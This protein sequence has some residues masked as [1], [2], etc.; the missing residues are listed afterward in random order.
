[1]H[2]DFAGVPA[3][4][5]TFAL[6]IVV[7]AV[8]GAYGLRRSG[9]PVRECVRIQVSLVLAGLVPA[10]TDPAGVEVSLPR[11]A[12][13]RKAKRQRQLGA[14]SLVIGVTAAVVLMIRATKAGV[15]GVN[16]GSC[17]SRASGI[18]RS[19]MSPEAKNSGGVEKS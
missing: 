19:V 1:M 6:G 18:S 16:E 17:V 2:P 3:Y 8:V 15:S 11:R 13:R 10:G 4:R 12:V 14:A 9:L 7:A 5:V